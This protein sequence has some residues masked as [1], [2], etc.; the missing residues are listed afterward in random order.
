[1]LGEALHVIYKDKFEL[2]C[3]D[4]NCT[5]PWVDYLDFTNKKH[6]LEDV[7][8]FKADYLFHIGGMIGIE[9]CEANRYDAYRVNATSVEDAVYISNRLGIPIVYINTSNIFN[10]TLFYHDEWDIPNPITIYAKSKYAGERFIVDNANKY[11]ICRCGWFFGGGPAKDKRFVGKI[12]Q[13]I[14]NGIT[15]IFAISD[16]WSTPTYTYDLAKVI[17]ELLDKEYWGIY[18]VSCMKSTNMYLVASEILKILGLSDKIKLT[19]VSADF[20][21]ETYPGERPVSEVLNNTK[22]EHRRIDI[23]RPWN[24]CLKEYIENYYHHEYNT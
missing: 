18:N 21:K 7:T 20:F 2:K 12:M 4:I 13:Q 3:T 15:E 23:M 5:D 11:L 10:D 16:R 9:A 19:G 8:A 1:M 6:Y 14:D 17:D 24:E 22:L